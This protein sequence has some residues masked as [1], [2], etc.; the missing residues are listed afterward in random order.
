MLTNPRSAFTDEQLILPRART[1]HSS[2]LTLGECRWNGPSC[3]ENIELLSSTFPSC[4]E[5]FAT[6]LGIPDA[7]AADVLDEIFARYTRV[8]DNTDETRATVKALLLTLS[9]YASTRSELSEHFHRLARLEVV[10]LRKARAM[11]FSTFVDTEWFIPDR[12]RYARTFE[13]EVWMLDF[14]KKQIE[15]LKPLFERMGINDRQISRHVREDTTTDAGYVAH[16]QLTHE[17]RAKARYIA[18]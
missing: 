12:I 6:T 9:T 7:G 15:S 11:K 13:G 3:L 18:L 17:L 10:P 14:D 16:P 2:W 4:K 8:S 1:P 5:L